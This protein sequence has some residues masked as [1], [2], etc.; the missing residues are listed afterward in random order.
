MLVAPVRAVCADGGTTV[1]LRDQALLCTPDSKT[2]WARWFAAVDPQSQPERLRLFPNHNLAYEAAAAGLGVA[3]GMPLLAEPFLRTRNLEA[4][5][6]ARLSGAGYRLYRLR[7][8]GARDARTRK[9]LDWFR[10]EAAKSE[11][12]FTVAA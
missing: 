2:D 4:C 12:L 5:G 1:S 8:S 7:R 10:R 6:P 9:L 11:Q 3:L